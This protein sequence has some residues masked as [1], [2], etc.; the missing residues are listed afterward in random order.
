MAL[1]IVGVAV[2]CQKDGGGID[3]VELDSERIL[4][5]IG[6]QWD[7][8]LQITKHTRVFTA[9]PGVLPKPSAVVEDELTAM[10]IPLLKRARL[11]V[12]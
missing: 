2:L 10:N 7:T 6:P 11:G 4:W 1:R 12:V 5:L 3:F 9:Q 8:P